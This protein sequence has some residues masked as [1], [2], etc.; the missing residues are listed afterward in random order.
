MEVDTKGNIYCF[1][2]GISFNIGRRYSSLLLVD[3]SGTVIYDDTLYSGYDPVVLFDEQQNDEI[4]LLTRNMRIYSLNKVTQRLTLKDSIIQS[5]IDRVSIAGKANNEYILIGPNKQR[6]FEKVR[7][8]I[9]PQTFE[10]IANEKEDVSG[11]IEQIL[12]SPTSETVKEL[13]SSLSKQTVVCRDYQ[14]SVQWTSVLE[15]DSV[16]SRKIIELEDGSLLVIGYVNTERV[17]RTD[18]GGFMLKI[19]RNGNELWRKSYHRLNNERYIDVREFEDIL[20]QD[21]RIL[22]CGTD[23]IA[24]AGPSTRI[25]ILQTDTSGIVSWDRREPIYGEGS[26]AKTL[27]SLD[28]ISFYTAGTCGESDHGEPERLYISKHKYTTTST[29]DVKSY[30]TPVIFPN[31]ASSKLYIN[32]Q[33]HQYRIIS[34]SGKSI[35]EGSI[36][37]GISISSLHR[38]VYFLSLDNK[39]ELIKFIKE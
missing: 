10:V 17:S 27:R 1:G 6:V 13:Y 31:P 8:R 28:G 22:I 5:N 14:G 11:T 34:V 36:T 15:G 9:N 32:R 29:D 25:Y 39:E 26:T 18:R 24:P 19:D 16:R 7:L 23:G 35:Q 12:D 2:S 20:L 30:E 4:N 21:N 38:G 37:D 33:Y 3:T